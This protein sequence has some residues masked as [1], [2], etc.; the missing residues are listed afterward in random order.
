MKPLRSKIGMN[1]L[2]AMSPFFGC[3]QRTS[4]SAPIN[5][6]E[7]WLNCGWNQTSNCPPA[8]AGR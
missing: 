3:R 4:L 6:P 8:S 7:E 5:A 1:S 2:G